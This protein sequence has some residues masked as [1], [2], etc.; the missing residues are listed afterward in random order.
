MNSRNIW[1][2]LT[3]GPG[4]RRSTTT[5]TR[6]SFDVKMTGLVMALYPMKYRSSGTDNMPCATQ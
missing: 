4:P 2:R 6:M 1:T 3:E 5:A